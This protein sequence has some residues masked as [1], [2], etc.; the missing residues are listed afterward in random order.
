MALGSRAV[1]YERA[2][3]QRRRKH[4]PSNLDGGRLRRT[5]L[6][7]CENVAERRSVHVAGHNLGLPMPALTGCGTPKAAAEAA[8]SHVFYL[9]AGD[10]TLPI[11]L[12]TDSNRHPRAAVAMLIKPETSPFSVGCWR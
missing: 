3:T 9:H 8:R 5:W 6:R 7:G 2:F 10:T 1:L 4:P 12:A 11:L